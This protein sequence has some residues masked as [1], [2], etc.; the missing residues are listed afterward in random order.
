ML[1]LINL[2]LVPH[3]PV[4]RHFAEADLNEGALRRTLSRVA[5]PTV[6]ATLS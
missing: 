6:E 1:S 3:D 2:V 4:E 5:E